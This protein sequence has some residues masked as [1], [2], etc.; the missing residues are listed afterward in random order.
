MRPL[1]LYTTLKFTKALLMKAHFVQLFQQ[2]IKSF[3][4]MGKY[5]ELQYSSEG[6]YVNC[7]KDG[8]T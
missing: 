4:D 7:T 8:A 2:M 5:S 6:K 1:R 3:N